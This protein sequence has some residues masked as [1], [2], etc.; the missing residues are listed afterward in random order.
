VHG[1]RAWPAVGTGHWALAVH[2]A[3]VHSLTNQDSCPTARTAARPIPEGMTIFCLPTASTSQ[4]VPRDCT[5]M[6]GGSTV[7]HP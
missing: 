4:I 6:T 1:Q 5:C 7:G 3:T 2:S